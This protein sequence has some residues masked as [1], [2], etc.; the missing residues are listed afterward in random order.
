MRS[1]E[2]MGL[3]WDAAHLD[4]RLAGKLSLDDETGIHWSTMTLVS[5]I[6]SLNR[7]LAQRSESVPIIVGL[8]SEGE[9]VTLL[10]CLPSGSSAVNFAVE[11]QSFEPHLAIFGAQFE[12]FDSLQFRSIDMS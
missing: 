1:F 2:K 6:D 5:G 3:G 12:L 8:T 10:D 7:A 11:N 4:R 9:D